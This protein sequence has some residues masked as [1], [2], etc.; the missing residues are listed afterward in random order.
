MDSITQVLKDFFSIVT[1]SWEQIIL[2]VLLLAILSI[3]FL[4]GWGSNRANFYKNGKILQTLRPKYVKGEIS[5]KEYEDVRREL[6]ESLEKIR[7][8]S[9]IYR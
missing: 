7:Y 9:K 4:I 1:A 5:R 3:V 8:Y 6:K 2:A